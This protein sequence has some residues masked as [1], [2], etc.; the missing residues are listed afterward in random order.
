MTPE[1]GRWGWH[2]HAFA[3]RVCPPWHRLDSVPLFVEMRVRSIVSGLQATL[4]V[5]LLKNI[6]L[7]LIQRT[8]KG[9]SV[10][11]N[12]LS[13][14]RQTAYVSLTRKYSYLSFSPLIFRWS[15]HVCLLFRLLTRGSFFAMLWRVV[16]ILCVVTA[17][18][19]LKSITPYKNT[20]AVN[21]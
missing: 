15:S 8:W 1:R 14:A 3:A 7:S 13:S 6:P 21:N 20:S 18:N 16:I 12:M 9:L 10:A 17:R 2:F 11:Y 19:S 5:K 4:N